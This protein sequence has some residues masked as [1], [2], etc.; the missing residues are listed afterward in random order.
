VEEEN[1]G[2]IKFSF[3]GLVRK[4][5]ILYCDKQPLSDLQQGRGGNEFNI[6][7]FKTQALNLLVECGV[8]YFN[9]NLTFQ[10]H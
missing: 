7:E 8:S 6:P 3:V 5:E 1:K 2:Q 9:Q 4:L 10:K